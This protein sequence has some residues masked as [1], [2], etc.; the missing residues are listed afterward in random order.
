MEKQPEVAIVKAN[1]LLFEGYELYWLFGRS[2]L[3]FVLKDV[4]VFASP[5]SA[6]SARYRDTMLPVVELEDYFGLTPGTATGSGQYLVV[7]TVRN[8][9][10]LVKIIVKTSYALKVHKLDAGF[11][12]ISSLRFSQN[13]GDVLGFYSFAQD[14]IAAIPDIAKIS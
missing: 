12:K 11:A 8:R 2:Q 10:K 9:T 3:E 4:E 6:G 5:S 1:C 7:R 13:G 14:K